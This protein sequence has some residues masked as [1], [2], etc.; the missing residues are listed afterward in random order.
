MA[1]LRERLRAQRERQLA[2]MTLTLREPGWQDPEVHVRYRPLEWERLVAMLEDADGASSALDANLNALVDAC[3]ALLV[4]DLEDE[5]PVSLAE[6]LRDQGET[7]TGEVKFS[8][9]AVEL[10]ELTVPDG[11]PDVLRP[12][13][14]A[15][16][17]ARALFAGAVSPEIAIAEHAARLGSWMRGVQE[18]VDGSLLGE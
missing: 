6:R 3:D 17:V 1:T 5:A 4:R 15:R 12:A 8:V 2:P 9:A 13:R 18:E 10:F 16:E 11:A 7:V 14:S